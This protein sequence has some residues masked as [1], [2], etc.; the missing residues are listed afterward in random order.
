MLP[1]VCLTAPF[2]TGIGLLPPLTS[3]EINPISKKRWNHPSNSQPYLEPR[4]PRD[5]I[6]LAPIGYAH[7][8]HCP[9][10]LSNLGTSHPDVNP[11]THTPN[12]CRSTTPSSQ[13]YSPHSSPR[14][15]GWIHS[16]ISNVSSSPPSHHQNPQ[17][18]QQVPASGSKLAANVNNPALDLQD[19]AIRV[20]HR[21]KRSRLGH[22]LAKL[23]GLGCFGR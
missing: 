15:S 18:A 2:A 19:Q 5:H 12:Q 3:G 10:R 22:E 9:T 16:S 13:R 7:L 11:Q 20:R 6:S 21:H 14:A 17:R 23:V 1:C 4:N 8:T